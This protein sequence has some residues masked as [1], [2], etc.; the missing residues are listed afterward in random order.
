MISE[1]IA[2][3]II[4]FELKQT[5]LKKEIDDELKSQKGVLLDSYT[6]MLGPVLKEVSTLVTKQL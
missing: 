3:G 4:S 1:Q 2:G 5:A 6:T